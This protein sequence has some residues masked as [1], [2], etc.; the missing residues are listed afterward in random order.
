VLLYQGEKLIK[1][2]FGVPEL[3]G[4]LKQNPVWYWVFLGAIKCGVLKIC[5]SVP[6]ILSLEEI[7]LL[8][9]QVKA[10]KVGNQAACGGKGVFYQQTSKKDPI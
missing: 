10:R 8:S 5:K 3:S 9:M 7:C 4:I 1:N 2:S 6:N